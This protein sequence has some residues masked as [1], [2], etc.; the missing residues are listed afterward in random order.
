MLKAVIVHM[1]ALWTPTLFRTLLR[2]WILGEVFALL[3]HHNGIKLI[4]C[5]RIKYLE[6]GVHR[7]GFK[8]TSNC[9][10]NKLGF[11]ISSRRSADGNATVETRNVNKYNHVSTNR[12]GLEKYLWMHSW[13]CHICTL[14]SLLCCLSVTA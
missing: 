12:Q 7:T 1:D 3:L 11:I 14:L 2:H 8:E 4:N 10:R 9:T 13:S 6:V 5:Q